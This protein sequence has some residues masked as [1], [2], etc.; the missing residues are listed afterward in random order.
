VAYVSSESG[1]PEIYVRRFPADGE[2][3]QISRSG[4]TTPRWSRNGKEIYF[5]AEGKLMA[6][7]VRLDRAFESGPPAALFAVDFVGD[8]DYEVAADG[9]LLV[10]AG[11]AGARR[12]GIQII[13]NWASEL[14]P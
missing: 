14:K 1:K 5:V 4:G 11:V 9:R 2:R 13:A 7:S 6:A 10:R 3:W 8:P 12:T